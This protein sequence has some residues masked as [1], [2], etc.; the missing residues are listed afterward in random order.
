MIQNKARNPQNTPQVT[1]Q[2]NVTNL[3][4]NQKRELFIEHLTLA[5]F[6]GFVKN[7]VGEKTYYTFTYKG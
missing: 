1:K 3:T 5:G 2:V 7:V 6:A 4:Q